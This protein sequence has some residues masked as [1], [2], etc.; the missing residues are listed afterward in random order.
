MHIIGQVVRLPSCFRKLHEIVIV[1][2]LEE[3]QRVLR[4]QQRILPTRDKG[5]R[6]PEDHLQ[7]RIVGVQFIRKWSE[8]GRR[9]NSSKLGQKQ[10]E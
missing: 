4:V 6:L 10:T 7:S 8:A 1:R 3:E 5:T 2:S 9:N